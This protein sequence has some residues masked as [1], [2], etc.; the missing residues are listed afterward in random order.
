MERQ[1]ISK[2][3]GGILDEI[4]RL[5]NTLYAMNMEDIQRYPDNYEIL[6]TD[7]SLRSEQISCRLR[8]LIYASTS[9]KKTEYMNSA[10]N[11]H[12]IQ[13]DNDAGITKITV[14]ALAPKR[15]Q[16]QSTEFFIDPLYFALDSY[17]DTHQPQKYRDCVVCFC[18]VYNRALPLRRIRDYDNLELKQIL[19]V[20]SIFWLVDD[21][22]QFCDAYHTTELGECDCTYIFIMEKSLF[23][24]WALERQIRAET[25]SD[26]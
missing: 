5:Q 8:H 17:H 26:F 20:I 22:G 21:S 19:D 24:Q 4:S 14:P 1:I 13:I 11:I 16:W 2:R 6:S 9:I 23:P 10:A 12:G 15:K 7:A 25:I 3:I 18:N